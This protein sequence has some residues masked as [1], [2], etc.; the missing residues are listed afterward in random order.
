MLELFAI[1]TNEFQ[2]ILRLWPKLSNQNNLLIMV[3]SSGHCANWR[4][5]CLP[6]ISFHSFG[7]ISGF[8]FM[9]KNEI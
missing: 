9:N 4:Y 5:I 2:G 6:Q 7:Y 8:A 3:S 1:D